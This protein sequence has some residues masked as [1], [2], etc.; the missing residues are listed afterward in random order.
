MRKKVLLF[1]GVMF[2]SMLFIGTPSYA[3]NYKKY[4]TKKVEIAETDDGRFYR[5]L[6]K[7]MHFFYLKKVN[8]KRYVNSWSGLNARKAPTLK[9]K[10]LKRL[11]HRKIVTVIGEQVTK[12]K[13]KWVLI[14]YK[15]K[16]AFVWSK[17]LSKKKPK[18]RKYLGKYTITAYE[19]TGGR[20]ANGNY[21][22]KG[23]TIA[24][25]SLKFGTKVYIQGVGVRV[26]EDSGASW[27]SSNWMD[28][29][30]GSVSACDKWGVRTRK[31][32]IIR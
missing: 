19:W 3:K 6:D 28:L 12:S 15:K 2:M 8:K 17:Y 20:C 1:L 27:H 32:W 26:V 14:K 11:K 24:C 23:R 10:V 25:N 5:I 21:P 9:S 31:V 30:L 4:Y 29:Y 16:Y 18:N 22:K 7:N 13:N